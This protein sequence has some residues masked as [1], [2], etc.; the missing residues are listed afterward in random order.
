MASE[1]RDLLKEF[2]EGN[3]QRA[4]ERNKMLQNKF[5]KE[6]KD[7]IQ[8]YIKNS[9][10]KALKQIDE[11]NDLK[12]N[13]DTYAETITKKSIL[14]LQKE[15]AKYSEKIKNLDKNAPT[16]WAGPGLTRGQLGETDPKS[17]AQ[18]GKRAC[19]GL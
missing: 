18:G 13:F 10:E 7:I 2:L 3:I 6:T 8:T 19:A 16:L 9:P 1:N 12:K 17:P 15:E 5:T 11:L 14:F 4:I